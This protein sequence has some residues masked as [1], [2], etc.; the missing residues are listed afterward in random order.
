MSELKS[1]KLSPRTA[2]GTVTL[3]TSGDTF[4]IPSGVTFA[5]SGT[6]TG[7]GSD[8]TP[9]FAAYNNA[10]QSIS[11]GTWTKLLYNTEYWDTDSAFASDRFTVPSGE[12]GKYMIWAQSYLT[13]ATYGDIKL[14]IYKNG[15]A[16]NYRY[17]M[18]QAGGSSTEVS[19]LIDLSV[20]DYLEVYLYGHGGA[21]V[22]A[23]NESQ[24]AG[25]KLVGV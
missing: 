16:T 5:N 19:A 18:I 8:S 9:S 25:F 23:A 24:F 7:F 21:V 15:S 17:V 1:D 22:T 14:Y 2:S 4:S 10:T 3:G 13:T 11:S 6:A 12:A 20:S